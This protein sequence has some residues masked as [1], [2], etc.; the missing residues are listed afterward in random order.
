MYAIDQNILYRIN[1]CHHASK[2]RR[3]EMVFLWTPP[4]SFPSKYTD[5]TVHRIPV[6]N[7]RLYNLNARDI[8]PLMNSMGFL[9]INLMFHLFSQARRFLRF[10]PSRRCL[11]TGMNPQ[12]RCLCKNCP[13]WPS[14]ERPDDDLCSIDPHVILPPAFPIPDDVI[15][16]RTEPNRSLSLTSH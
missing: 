8:F 16:Q 3:Q 15:G 4:H 11:S 10:A 7:R 2:R 13:K 5:E 1:S 6:Q 9:D 12:G 14:A